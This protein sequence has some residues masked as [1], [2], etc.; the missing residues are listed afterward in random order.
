MT[1]LTKIWGGAVV[2]CLAAFVA[3]A[4]LSAQIFEHVPHSEDEVAYL[5][6]AKVFAQ[7]R[8]T[9]PTPPL[10]EAFWSPFV[11]D[12]QGWRFGKYQPG[13]PL[14]LSLGVRLNAPW[15]INAMLGTLTLVLIAWLGYGYY[16]TRDKPELCLL[17]V[18][19]AGLGLITPGFLFLSS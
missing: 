19:A 2:I 11:V 8:V 13:W 9:V 7:N 10:E 5:F 16:C 18:I 4:I 1:H 17:P 6:Q 14:L 15:L 12:Y 3:I